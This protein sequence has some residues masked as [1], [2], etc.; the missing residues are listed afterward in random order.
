MPEAWSTTR[1]VRAVG[2]ARGLVTGIVI[3][4]WCGTREL[5][6]VRGRDVDRL[7]RRLTPVVDLVVAAQRPAAGPAA[8]HHP[9]TMTNVPDGHRVFDELGVGRKIVVA[10]LA[11]SGPAA[12]QRWSRVLAATAAR[13]VDGEERRVMRPAERA[14]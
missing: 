9:L 2:R 1:L 10:E 12:M 3:V 8:D 4:G 6:L 13:A 14:G 11:P 7:A 5:R